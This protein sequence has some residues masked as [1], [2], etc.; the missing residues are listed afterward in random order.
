MHYTGTVYRA[1]MDAMNPLLEITQGC[2]HNRCTFC[3]MYKDVHFKMSPLEWVEEDLRE[4]RSVLPH[5]KRLTF[6]GANPFVLPYKKLMV[7]LDLVHKYLPDVDYITTQTR[8]SDIQ[9]KTVDQLKELHAN[10]IEKLYLGIESG[11]DWTLQRINKGYTS[12][13]IVPQS[14]KLEQAGIK[15]W[16]TFLNGIA[17]KE[18]SYDHALHSAQIFSQLHPEA[19]GSGS[20]VLFPDTALAK[21]AQAGLFTPL[22][23]KERMEEM[24]VFLENL[25]M[26]NDTQFVM[27][28]TS[29]LQMNGHIPHDQGKLIKQLESA[30]SN[31]DEIEGAMEYHRSHTYTL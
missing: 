5:T 8:V 4:I 19:I 1:P 31:Y 17:D 9:N 21:E 6:I 16:L 26:G 23:E 7:I 28:H 20:L 13:I 25:H 15:Y 22:T 24:K 27:H 3:N 29:A 10:G 2:S 18:H 14:L 30:I 12:D 11:D